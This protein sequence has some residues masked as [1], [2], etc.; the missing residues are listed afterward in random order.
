[1]GRKDLKRAMNKLLGNMKPFR[2]TQAQELLKSRL[3][4]YIVEMEAVVDVTTMG[5]DELVELTGS[6]NLAKWAKDDPSF[7]PWLLDK[8]YS[9]HM[10][11]SGAEAAIVLLREIMDAPIV[12]KELT[13]KDKLVAATTFL[14]LD[15]R[16]PNKRKELVFL[17]QE[18]AKL[19]DAE[20][21]KQLEQYRQK[22]VE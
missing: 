11:K 16:F 3:Q 19:T 21:A 4:D 18:V 17:D 15:D 6:R 1:M 13:A 2:P 9:R 5:L 14:N 10:I 22:L 20:V 8:D 12:P 7:I